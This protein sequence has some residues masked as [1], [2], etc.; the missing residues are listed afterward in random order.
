MQTVLDFIREFY[1]ARAAGDL[2]ALRDF[3]ADDVRWIEPTV[4]DHM[5][6]LTG[7]DAVINMIERAQSATNGT[8]ALEVAQ[9]LEVNGHCSVVINWSAQKGEHLIHGRELATYSVENGKIVFALFLPENLEHDT[10]F[11]S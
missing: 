11:W 5:G 3:I 7:Q 4:A 9:G 8:F 2:N 6:A 10:Q 1:V